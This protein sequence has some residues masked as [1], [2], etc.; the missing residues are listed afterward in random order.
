MAT[1]TP[2]PHRLSCCPTLQHG[3]PGQ[4]HP[5]AP[6]RHLQAV[7][8]K[9]SSGTVL[10]PSPRTP[11]ARLPCKPNCFWVLPLSSLP[12]SCDQSKIAIARARM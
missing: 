12:V 10:Y 2:Q 9:V 1:S 5:K 11:S 7:H 3:R 6:G 8:N 4:P